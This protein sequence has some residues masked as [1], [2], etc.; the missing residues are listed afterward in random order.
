MDQLYGEQGMLYE[1]LDVKST[2]LAQS[3]G[4]MLAEIHHGNDH[5]HSESPTNVS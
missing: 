4:K 5:G 1:A 3:F 2:S